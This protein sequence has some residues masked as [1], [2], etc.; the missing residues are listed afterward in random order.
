MRMAWRKA[1]AYVCVLIERSS[2]ASLG[3]RFAT[4]D[5]TLIYHLFASDFILGDTQGIPRPFESRKH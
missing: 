5:S 1:M 2:S 3:A 4:H